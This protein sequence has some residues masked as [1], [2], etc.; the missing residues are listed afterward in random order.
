MKVFKKGG[1][2]L[3][4]KSGIPVVPIACCGTRDMLKKKSF[5]LSGNTLELHI[6]K[7]INSKQYSY[8]DRNAFVEEIRTNVIALKDSWRR[9]KIL[10]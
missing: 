1:L 4:I 3:G 6:G 8:E 9:N 2:L 5:H 10:S 7:P